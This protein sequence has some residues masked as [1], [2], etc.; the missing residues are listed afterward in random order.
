MSELNYWLVFVCAAV[1]L[2]ISPGPDLLYILSRTIAQGR[3][4]GAASSAGVCTGS[5]VH[6]LGAAFG[7]SAILAA[8]ALAFGIV[9]YVGALYLFYLGI[10]ALRSHGSATAFAEGTETPR[11]TAWQ[12]F[13]QGMLIDALNPKAAIFFLA[14]LPQ[15]VRPQHGNTAVQLVTLGLLVILIAFPIELLFVQAAAQTTRFF[16]RSPKATVWL[17]RALGGIFISLGLRL[18]LLQ[19]RT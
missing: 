12:A 17:D 18:A 13:R 11:V 16:R 2:T 10:Q 15:F 4:I 1:M 3:R 19:Q 7:L 9:K 6:V 5:I 14:F 8:S